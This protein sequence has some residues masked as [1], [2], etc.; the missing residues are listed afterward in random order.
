MEASRIN[1]KI[2]LTNQP[3]DAKPVRI[4]KPDNRNQNVTCH[5]V[6]KWI[7]NKK[8]APGSEAKLIASAKKMPHGAMAHFKRN[9]RNYL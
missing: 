3:A 8:L 7:K 4:I 1:L 9:W 5:D 6:V 2:G